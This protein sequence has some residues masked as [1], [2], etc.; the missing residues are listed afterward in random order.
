MCARIYGISV[1]GW[2]LD[3]RGRVRVPFPSVMRM[4][5]GLMLDCGAVSSEP[6]T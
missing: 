5:M 6:C 1:G 4:G 2:E 3:A